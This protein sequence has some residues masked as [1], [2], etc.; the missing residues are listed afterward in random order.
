[1]HRA[2]AQAVDERGLHG[3]TVDEIALSAGVSQRTFFNYFATKEDAV[4]GM[5]PPVLGDDVVAAYRADASESLF[6]RA[7]HLL[8]AVFGSMVEP[9]SER[10]LV[11]LAREYP[12]LRRRLGHH[13]SAAEQL[14]E[15]YLLTHADASDAAGLHSAEEAKALV[16]LA[17]TVLRYASSQL[18]H[19]GSTPFDQDAVLAQTLAIFRK[20]IRTSL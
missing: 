18:E 17:G 13:I 6:T 12:E 3:V 10:R 2:A 1:V 16:A 8:A 5:R 14:V 19:D 7:V 4:L 9:N 11:G 15:D 20:A